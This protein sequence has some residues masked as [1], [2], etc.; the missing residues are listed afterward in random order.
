[1]RARYRS[2]E[3]AH[4]NFA[5]QGNTFGKI[6]DIQAAT[7][8]DVAQFHQTYFAPANAGLALVG[9]FDPKVAKERIR[10]YFEGIPARTAAPAIDLREPARSAEQRE[11][12]TDPSAQ[13]LAVAMVW[14]TPATTDPDWFAVKRLGE[15]LGATEAAR[16]HSAL[17]KGA[18]VAAGVQVNLEDTTGP[19]LLVVVIV[20]SP[21]KDPAQ[22]EK[23]ALQE[24][25][26]IARE[27]VMQAELDRLEAD[28]LRRR[29]LQLVTTTARAS[30]FSVFQTV[31]GNVNAVN[32]WERNESKVT[33]DDL[34][35]VAQKY[36]T[37][38]NRSVILVSPAG[39]PAGV[40][41]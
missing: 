9:D 23:L 10:H 26:R 17:V 4:Q 22:V 12:M 5:N 36:F 33:S 13:A 41:P 7:I 6:E 40:K 3:L 21:G 39:A 34:R 35:R 1:V 18:G 32:D 29:A 19:N 20:V 38:A 15:V 27:G 25:D 24:I 14:S 30:V 8:D 28:A 37:P 31:Y 2:N 16:L 11:S